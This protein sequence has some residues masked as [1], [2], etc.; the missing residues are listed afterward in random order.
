MCWSGEA[1]AILAIGGFAG[2]AYSYKKGEAPELCAALVYFSGME[3]LQAFTYS[4]IDRC[5]LPSNQIATIIG[6]VHIAFQPFFINMV[7]MHFIPEMVR[8]KIQPAVYF[9]CLV[10]AIFYLLRLYPFEWSTPC[11]NT[12]YSFS[13]SD[14]LQIHVPFCGPK[15]CS[16]HGVWHIAWAI[17]A[18]VSYIFDNSYLFAGFILPVLYGSWRLTLYHLITGPMLA[19][20]TTN[21]S[22]EFVAVWCLYSIGLLALL[23]K[24][25]IRKHLYVRRWLWW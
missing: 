24:T 9:I 11:F 15:T 17:P 18:N 21:N 8:K 1:S 14:N 7:S 25:P 2:A 22:N 3:A 19:W 23:I 16:T 4:V 12:H 13:F 10:A 20:L 5:E 6:Y